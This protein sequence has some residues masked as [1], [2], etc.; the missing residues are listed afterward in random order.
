MPF[1]SE[2][3]NHSDL[4]CIFLTV[5]FI[6]KDAVYFLIFSPK[7]T[8]LSSA[9]CLKIFSKRINV[10]YM[11]GYTMR[12][13]VPRPF[14]IDG[15]SALS[16]HKKQSSTYSKYACGCFLYAPSICI[17]YFKRLTESRILPYVPL[18]KILNVSFLLKTIRKSLDRSI[19][20]KN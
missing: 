6:A 15:A 4:F 16:L 18:L 11:S 1:Q 14:E 5:S 9:L 10:F 20:F 17:V 8:A 2:N 3:G 12:N 7:A 19:I 13:T